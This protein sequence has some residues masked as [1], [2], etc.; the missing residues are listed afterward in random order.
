MTKTKT[1]KKP[2]ESAAIGMIKRRPLCVIDE[3]LSK[4]FFL[5]KAKSE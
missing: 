3:A 4:N 5:S 2:K 1:P